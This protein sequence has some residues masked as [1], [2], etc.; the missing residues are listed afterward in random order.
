MN[1]WDK[2]SLENLLFWKRAE[3]QRKARYISAQ[4]YLIK[5]CHGN[6]SANCDLNKEKGEKYARSVGRKRPCKNF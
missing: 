5:I 6:I 2:I 3:F 4:K 1:H